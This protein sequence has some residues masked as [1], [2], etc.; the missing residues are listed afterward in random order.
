MLLFIVCLS[1]QLDLA[2]DRLLTQVVINLVYARL[3]SGVCQ[4]K[5][6][7]Q[8]D[9]DGTKRLAPSG[10]LRRCFLVGALRSLRNDFPKLSLSTLTFWVHSLFYEVSPRTKKAS[11]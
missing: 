9:L 1:S 10:H 7:L 8:G 6:F 2:Q 4:P 3:S 11:G 5:S